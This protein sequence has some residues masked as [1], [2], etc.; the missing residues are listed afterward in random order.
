M[1]V[2]YLFDPVKQ[3]VSRNG[4]PLVGGFL[5]VFVGESQEPAATY[6]D[7]EGTVMNPRNI[8]IDSAGRALGVFVDDSK[9]Y[10]LKVYNSGGML[11]FSIYPVTPGKGSGGGTIITPSSMQHWLGMYGPTYTNFPGDLAG[12]TLGIPRQSIDY[13]GDFI[14]RIETAPYPDEVVPAY[15]YLKPGLYHIECVIRYQQSNEDVKN[16]LDEV[17]VYTGNGNANEDV[18]YQL[19]ASGPETNGNRHCLKQ[20]FIR[21]VTETSG[22]LLYFAPGT[23]TDWTDAYIQ[24]LS[25]VKLDS[26]A[27]DIG[28]QEVYHDDT[29]TGNGTANDPLSIQDA[30]DGKQDTLTAG[31]GIIL[32]SDGNISVDKDV[33]QEKLTAGDNITIDSDGVISTEG[34]KYTEGWGID[35]DNVNNTISADPDEVQ[36]K[37]TAGVGINLDS[38]GN[39]SGNYRGGYNIEVT[40]NTINKLGHKLIATNNVSYT[41]C[42]VFDFTWQYVYGR[43]QTVFSATHYGGNF[44]TFSVTLIRAVGTNYTVAWPYVVSASP[45]MAKST[46]FIEKLEIRESGNRIIGY[47]KLR[48][49]SQNQF[50]LD[51]EGHSDAGYVSF[52]PQLT[53]EP[54]GEIAWTCEVSNHDV[55]YYQDEINTN[56][57][58]KLTA[59]EHITID[60]DCVISTTGLDNSNIFWAIE[61]VT[62]YEEVRAAYDAKKCIILTNSNRSIV[63]GL[64]R[65]LSDRLEF[66]YFPTVWDPNGP[67]IRYV[68]ILQNDGWYAY[69]LSTQA[70]WNQSNNYYPS[71]IKNKPNLDNYQKKLTAGDNITIDSDGVISADVGEHVQADWEQN[72]SE[73]PSY[74]RNKPDLSEYQKALTAGD[75]ILLDSDGNISVDKETIQEKL[76]PGD[77]IEINSDG[78]IRNTYEQVQSDWEQEDSA[79]PSYIKNK[80]DLSVYQKELTAGNGI[81]LD[82]DGN[83]SVDTDVIQEKL[84]PGDGISIDSDG[85]ISNTFEQVQSDWAQEDAG[86]PDYIKNKPNM[87]DYQKALTAGEGIILDS[88]GNISVD[89]EDVQEKLTPGEGINIDSDGVIT[90]DPQ[91]QADWEQED[92]AEP[93]YI[94]N[95]PDLSIYQKELTAGDGIIL[96]SDGNISV[97]KETIQEKLTP[98]DG[99]NIDS[100]GVITADPQVQSDWEQEDDSQP[101]FIKNK[102]DLSE[103]QKELTA[104]EGITIINNIISVDSDSV[105]EKLTPGEGINIDSDG[106]I[107]AEGKRYTEGWGID[108]DDEHDIISVDPDIIQQKLIPGEG[109]TID[110]DGNIDIDLPPIKPLIAGQG[111]TIEDS[112]GVVRISTDAVMASEL[113]PDEHLLRYEHHSP[114]WSPYAQGWDKWSYDQNNSYVRFGYDTVSVPLIELY[115][116]RLEGFR[117]RGM[118]GYPDVD[119]IDSDGNTVARAPFITNYS[120]LDTDKAYLLTPLS[121]YGAKTY[122][123][124]EGQKKLTA[125]QGV[126]ID[127]DG[128]I[129]AEGRQYTAGNGINIDGNNEI[130]VDTSVV[131]EKL[132]AGQNINIDSDG[133]IS[134]AGGEQVQSDWDEAD[135]SE[136]SYIQNKPTPKTLT[137]GQN[138]T[139]TEDSSTITIDA[140]VPTYTAGDG[141]S[142]DSDGEVSA[143]IGAGLDI[144]SDGQIAVDST[145]ATKNYV[146]SIVGDIQT[147]LE[148]I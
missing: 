34:R 38:D 52:T 123:L 130:S 20:S 138:I 22:N 42:K 39:I 54:E 141:I 74:I 92:S 58:Q 41:Y 40:G 87:D 15:I 106:V 65:V 72:D 102:P 71:F 148:G 69:T 132:T 118:S 128:V 146:D 25:I 11:Q 142:I 135:D 24:T 61:G 5:N 78:V 109:I 143:K 56:F 2:A 26:V 29:M 48:N 83:I 117:V 108:I 46:A 131:Q 55:P 17:L 129:T 70:D 95:K 66:S 133:V 127:S 86:E 119:Y 27:H 33:I 62:T 31:E 112:D 77:G 50:W 103:Y 19:D 1:S 88:D 67:S 98:G 68:D 23:P 18:A 60:S 125:G 9:L 104:G 64:T 107:T 49:F 16:T 91:V 21:K 32:D 99:I 124:V 8:P 85:V 51:W 44:V 94:R 57:Q 122:Q 105:Q 89:K 96:D 36:R 13:E 7:P 3:F 4:I 53:N 101:D 90:A 147:I 47:L 35:V 111:I 126:N 110:S 6:S 79:D 80:P 116:S 28:L 113:D 139:I 134:A 120:G 76:T 75:G 136:P 12:H 145:I 63:A 10:T 43:G 144:D 59:G 14:D 140:D 114:T 82:S 73:D 121:S 100:N 45:N 137:A 115:T 37:L 97:D 30:L 81:D 84:T 93:D